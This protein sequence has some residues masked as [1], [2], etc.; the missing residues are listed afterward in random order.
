[1]AGGFDGNTKVVSLSK[2]YTSLNMLN[3]CGIDRVKR[4]IPL[5]AATTIT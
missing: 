5:G 4:D 2:S 3:C 1:V